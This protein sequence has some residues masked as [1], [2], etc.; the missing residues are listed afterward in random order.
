MLKEDHFQIQER[1]AIIRYH[2]NTLPDV[3]NMKKI[4]RSEMVMAWDKLSP[5]NPVV[6]VFSNVSGDVLEAE[7]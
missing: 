1:F 6:P 4:Q 7:K 3:V 5:Q 2:W